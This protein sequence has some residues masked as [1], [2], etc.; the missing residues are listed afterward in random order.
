MKVFVRRRQTKRQ[1]N[2]TSICE[3]KT[4]QLKL[5]TKAIQTVSEGVNARFSAKGF[6]AT[7]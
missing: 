1:W 7:H 4:N 3:D 6:G 2:M 5:N